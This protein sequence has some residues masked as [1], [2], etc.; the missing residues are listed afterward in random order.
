MKDDSSSQLEAEG[1]NISSGT[2]GTPYEVEKSDSYRVVSRDH[3]LPNYS[4]QE[5]VIVDLVPPETVPEPQNQ[6]QSVLGNHDYWGKC[7]YGIIDPRLAAMSMFQKDSDKILQHGGIFIIFADSR[8]PHEVVL[9]QDTNRGLSLSGNT[10]DNWDFLSEVDRS[11]LKVSSTEGSE[12]SVVSLKGILSRVL[13]RYLSGAKFSCTFEPREYVQIGSMIVSRN[14]RF[15]GWTTIAVNKYGA[16]VA[17]V[18]GPTENSQGWIFL[19]PQLAIKSSFLLDLVKEVLPELAPELF[20][21]SEGQQWINRKEYQ[22]PEVSRLKEKVEAIKIDAEDRIRSIEIE[23]E[24]V[25]NETAYLRDLLTGSGDSLVTAVSKAFEV[26]GFEVL[27]MDSEFLRLGSSG[28]RREDLRIISEPTILLVEV[29]GIAGLPADAD[30]LQVQKYVT[31]RMR[32]LNTVDI[33]GLSI[34]NHQK[35]LPPLHRENTTPFRDDI[36]VNA[37]DQHFGL[38]T[39]WDLYRMTTSF[40]KNGWKREH[41][42]PCFFQVGRISAIPMHYHLLGVVEHYWE[43]VKA[44]GIRIQTGELLTGGTVAFELPIEFEEQR[45]ESLQVEGKQVDRS[46]LSAVVGITTHLDKA[47]LKIGTRVY[48]VTI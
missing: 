28:F 41:I 9:A 4:E 12:I 24:A 42:K 8:T 48:L 6:R 20:A 34:I 16:P 46:G 29:K 5:I 21:Y 33:Q 37:E 35:A 15:N 39:T 43:R 17:G 11:R 3:R 23:I 25:E 40:L 13:T 19:F 32:E 7:N 44:V 1:F 14:E 47:R 26:L 38:M 2:F 18:L 31:V 22:M 36:L 27:D 30:A 45:V 10:Y